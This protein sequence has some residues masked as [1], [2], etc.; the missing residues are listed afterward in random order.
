MA[1]R[2]SKTAYLLGTDREYKLAKIA[3]IIN[4]VN[5]SESSSLHL[6]Q[7]ITFQSMLAAKKF[8]SDSES[9]SLYSICYPEDTPAVPD[10]F[11]KLPEMERSILDMGAFKVKKKLPLM[12]DIL[13]PIKSKE[14][15][16]YVIYTNVDIALM[17]SFYDYIQCKIGSGADSF[18]INRRTIRHFTKD[19][20]LADLY[21]RIGFV[22]AGYDCF[23]FKR[24]T[25]QKCD[26]GAA[27]IGVNWIGRALY[28]NLLAHSEKLEVIKHAHLTFHLGDDMEWRSDKFSDYDLHN[29]KE[30][31]KLINTILASP[32]TETKSIELKQILSYMNAWGNNTNVSLLT[33]VYNRLKSMVS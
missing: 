32:I 18:I 12:E 13:S 22:H 31:E 3:H 16:D 20:P 1:V 29:K 27:C 4:P 2:C 25:L 19:T 33:R 9:V 6:A 24:K 17:P 7:Q 5:V 8:C 28:A 11:I 23:V 21:S 10:H 30:V 15:I 14:N 26:F